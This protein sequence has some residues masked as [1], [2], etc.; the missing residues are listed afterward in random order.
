VFPGPGTFKQTVR[1][2]ESLSRV[3]LDLDMDIPETGPHVVGVGVF[4]ILEVDPLKLDRIE[5]A[6]RTLVT[7][8]APDLEDAVKTSV[9]NGAAVVHERWQAPPGPGYRLRTRMECWSSTSN[10]NLAQ[11]TLLRLALSSRKTT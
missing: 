10:T 6:K 11:T 5:Q 7:V 2:Y 8:L 1:F 4:L 9:R 3:D